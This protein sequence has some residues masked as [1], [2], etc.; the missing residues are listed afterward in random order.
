MF[1]GVI[2]PRISVDNY[3]IDPIRITSVYAISLS[4]A[5]LVNARFG[6]SNWQP[7]EVNLREDSGLERRLLRSYDALVVPSLA[8]GMSLV[9]KESPLVNERQGV[10][11]LSSASG[12][13]HH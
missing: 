7:I 5:Q 4:T 2:W 11:I 9:A 12:A 1:L 10:L 6:T 3:V 8:D 13:W